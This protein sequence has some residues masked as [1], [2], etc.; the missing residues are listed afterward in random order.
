M[1]AD[2]GT[3]FLTCPSV[4]SFVCY[5]TCEHIYKTNC[6]AISNNWHKWSTGQR[7]QTIHFGGR[8]V[9]NRF[10]GLVRHHSGPTPPLGFLIYQMFT[11]VLYAPHRLHRALCVGYTLSVPPSSYLLLSTAASTLSVQTCVR[12]FL[13]SRPA[14]QQHSVPTGDGAILQMHMQ[15]PTYNSPACW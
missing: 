4:H 15:A 8:E 5:Q 6:D 1:L 14:W 12:T 2:G 10:G 13:L 3:M 7:H 11:N 9:W